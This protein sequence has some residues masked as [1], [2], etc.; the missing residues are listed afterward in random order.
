MPAGER[1]VVPSHKI[2]DEFA[3][4][5]GKPTKSFRTSPPGR[6]GSGSST[7]VSCVMVSSM[8]WSMSRSRNTALHF[9]YFPRPGPRPAE[10]LIT[11]IVSAPRREGVLTYHLFRFF[12]APHRTDLIC[13]HFGYRDLDK[14]TYCVHKKTIN[15]NRRTVNKRKPATSH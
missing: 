4:K 1:C 9:A 13:K 6:A 7:S 10:L 8:S 11:T 15:D 2:S 5:Q 3:W 14:C 12:T